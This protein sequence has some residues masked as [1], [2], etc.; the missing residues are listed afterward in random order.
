MIC[1]SVLLF[2]VYT[3]YRSLPVPVASH[4][5]GSMDFDSGNEMDDDIGQF[6]SS[7]CWRRKSNMVVAGNSTGSLKLLQLI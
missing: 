7:V 3:Y 4:K 2:Q 6:V 1:L 5:F